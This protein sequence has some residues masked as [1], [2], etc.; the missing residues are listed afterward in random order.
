MDRMSKEQAAHGRPPRH[1]HDVA[2]AE[3]AP[4][5]SAEHQLL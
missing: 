1:F 4:T 2:E 5:G 3:R